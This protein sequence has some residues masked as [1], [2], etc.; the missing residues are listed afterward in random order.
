MTTI[1]NQL[2]NMLTL[3]NLIFGVI[4]I[5][6]GIEG[7]FLTGVIFI[8]LGGVADMFDG[9]VARRLNIASKIGK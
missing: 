7:E 8:M 9:M 6:F 5:H 3:S 4:A 1:R 2:A